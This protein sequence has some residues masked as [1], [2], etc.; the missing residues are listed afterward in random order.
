MY[1]TEPLI[2]V[3]PDDTV[4]RVHSDGPRT[5]AAIGSGR[6]LSFC[7]DPLDLLRL[8][9]SA[10]NA[11]SDHYLPCGCRV[12]AIVAE[13]AHP[14]TCSDDA[15]RDAVELIRSAIDDARGVA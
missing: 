10:A 5:Y 1:A 15:K 14:V 12:G 3:S 8:F 4:R 7:G 13:G 2:I 6:E 11:L 9:L